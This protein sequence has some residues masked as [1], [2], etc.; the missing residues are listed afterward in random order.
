MQKRVGKPG[1][2]MLLAGCSRNPPGVRGAKPLE[3][4]AA[5]GRF[6]PASAVG[7]EPRV[8][9]AW[10]PRWQLT[11]AVC[12]RGEV[13]EGMGAGTSTLL[14]PKAAWASSLLGCFTSGGKLQRW[15]RTLVWFSNAREVLP[16]GWSGCKSTS[17]GMPGAA[18][19]L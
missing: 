9:P 5:P 7:G 8:F 11:C 10:A 16:K 17:A 4:A 18:G 6:S 3:K 12:H 15:L 14:P 19:R 2:A 1:L 13:A